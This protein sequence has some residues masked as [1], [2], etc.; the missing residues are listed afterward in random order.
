MLLELMMKLYVDVPN[1]SVNIDVYILSA[2]YYLYIRI[3]MYRWV[4][5]NDVTSDRFR[6]KKGSE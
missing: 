6:Q 4:N 1:I 2:V 5:Y 3:H